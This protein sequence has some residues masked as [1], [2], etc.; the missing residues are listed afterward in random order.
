[1]LIASCSPTDF[2][3]LPGRDRPQLR[4]RP[5]FLHISAK[6]DNF[7]RCSSLPRLLL[8]HT[9]P[10]IRLHPASKDFWSRNVWVCEKNIR[11][12]R[13]LA[14]FKRG[15][16]SVRRSSF[17]SYADAL[18]QTIHGKSPQWNLIKRSSSLFSV[19]RGCIPNLLGSNTAGTLQRSLHQSHN[20]EVAHL[21]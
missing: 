18:F 4:D 19:D 1:M 3:V 14:L 12:S 7:Q 10:W 16:E 9:W 5:P 11:W 17:S 6:D 15:A 20:P 8:F 21:M 2:D 13:P